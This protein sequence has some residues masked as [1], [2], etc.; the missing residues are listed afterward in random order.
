MMIDRKI[1][2]ALSLWLLAVCSVPAIDNDECMVCHEDKETV[3]S[4]SEGMRD[5]LFVDNARF[6]QSV[7]HAN[8]IQCV[9]CHSDIVELDLDSDVPHP[10]SL[11]RVTCE[12]C[13]SD[14]GEAYQHSVHRKAKGKGVTIHCHACHEYHYA[15]HLD[16]ATVSER[17]N[18]FCLKCHDPDK[19]HGWL[20]RKKTHFQ[21]VEC[22]VCHVH[23][24]V[25]RY[26]DLRFYDNNEKKFLSGMEL[27]AKLE[28]DHD[29]FAELI[30]RDGDTIISMSEMAHLVKRIKTAGVSG[31]FHGEVL[32]DL[33]PDVHKI[34][35]GGASRDCNNCHHPESS[36]FD[37]VY[38][39]LNH[40][41]GSIDRHRL[42]REVLG[43]YY[44]NHFYV[45]GSTRVRV[46]DKIGGGL[47]FV[48]LLGVGFHCALRL[49]T[50][51]LRRRLRK[52]EEAG[53]HE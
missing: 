40:A 46:L 6:E 33:V 18:G 44:V 43:S 26:V 37:N 4:E 51:N 45:M 15:S 9:D 7:H 3:R 39:T 27:L 8:E 1:L 50:M 5:E 38:I 49:F 47:L 24:D 11:K 41:D 35:R 22:A 32:V 16:A 53:R 52:E 17:K 13:H 25:P 31:T 21:H 30:D 2:V 29:A 28:T 42:S 10:V 36:N 14:E 19:F 48:G 12:D 34:E 23:V 20:P